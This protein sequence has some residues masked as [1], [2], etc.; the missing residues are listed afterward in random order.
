MTMKNSQFNSVNLTKRTPS[1]KPKGTKI[2]PPTEAPANTSLSPL[3]SSPKKTYS[4][5][6]K[7]KK[8]P[9][10]HQNT[11][12]DN[13]PTDTNDA[14]ETAAISKMGSYYTAT[15]S[16]SSS[17]SNNDPFGDLIDINDIE[18]S[19]PS[20]CKPVKKRAKSEEFKVEG[21]I[22]ISDDDDEPDSGNRSVT[23]YDDVIRKY[24]N[25]NIPKPIPTRVELLKR[26]EKYIDVIEDII[27]GKIGTSC[28]YELAKKQCME[29]PHETMSNSDKFK[30][31]WDKYFGGYY[32][33]Q[34]QSII[35]NYIMDKLESKLIKFSNKNRTASYWNISQFSTYVLANEIII[36]LIMEDMELDFDAAESFCQQTTDY[37]IIVADASDIDATSVKSTPVKNKK[38]KKWTTA[39]DSDDVILMPT[40]KKQ[41]S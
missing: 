34:R 37:G 27:S 40:T 18:K 1:G 41:K 6:K 26:A 15:Q 7:Q 35:G 29:S 8:A 33:F 16:S 3:F 32:G 2:S 5:R 11:P 13:K 24:K 22:E 36:R 12:R 31:K 38:K 4:N 14:L 17:R 30:I 23:Q 19:T 28:Y 39:D 21:L 25:K 10:V 9:V 20:P